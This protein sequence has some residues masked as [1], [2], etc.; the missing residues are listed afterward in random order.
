M[1]IDY[2]P[3]AVLHDLTMFNYIMGEKAQSQ[4]QWYDHVV[5]PGSIAYRLVKELKKFNISFQNQNIK[6]ELT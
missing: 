5:L 3:L 2:V 6:V 4:F 1:K